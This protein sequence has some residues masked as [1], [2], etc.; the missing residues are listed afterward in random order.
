MSIPELKV[1]MKVHI[2]DDFSNVP[3]RGKLATITKKM[4]YCEWYSVDID[5]G[6]FSWKAE[7]FDKVICCGAKSCMW[8]KKEK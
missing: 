3:Y 2:P 1:G 6:L 4:G 8:H 7:Y 5:N